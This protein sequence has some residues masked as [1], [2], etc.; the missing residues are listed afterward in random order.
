VLAEPPAS[1]GGQQRPAE[2]PPVGQPGPLGSGGQVGLQ[3]RHGARGERVLRLPGALAD[4]AQDPVAG[5]L[6]EVGD[7]GGACLIDAQG[8]V[9]QQPHHRCGAQRLGAGVGGGDQGAGLVAVQPDGGGLV[10]VHHGAGTPATA[11]CDERSMRLSLQVDG[12]TS[13]AQTR[14]IYAGLCGQA[15]APASGN[16]PARPGP[17]HN[18]NIGI[19]VLIRMSG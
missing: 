8:V 15:T 19:I 12:E 7:V 3:G 14:S 16:T 17:R 2:L 11:D 10:R 4:Y 9:Q 18:G 13:L 1:G 5:V 6:A